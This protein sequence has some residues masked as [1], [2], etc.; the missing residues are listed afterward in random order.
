[1]SK[2]PRAERGDRR[3]LFCS[4]GQGQTE[5][6]R[7]LEAKNKHVKFSAINGNKQ[8]NPKQNKRRGVKVAGLGYSMVVLPRAERG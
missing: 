8:I 1:M 4:K 5:R 2:I 6:G 3:T 7:R